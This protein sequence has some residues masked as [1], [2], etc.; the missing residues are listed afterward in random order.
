M[1][2][3]SSARRSQACDHKWCSR[4]K[5]FSQKQHW[6]RHFAVSPLFLAQRSLVAIFTTV[7]ENPANAAQDK[8]SQLFH[9]AKMHIMID[10]ADRIDATE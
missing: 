4:P 2:F 1:H 6:T 3:Q 5:Q 8:A 9:D 7:C 10:F